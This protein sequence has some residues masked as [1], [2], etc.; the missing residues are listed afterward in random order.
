MFGLELTLSHCHLE[1]LP[2]LGIL[3]VSRGR[4]RTLQPSS[5]NIRSDVFLMKSLDRRSR[6]RHGDSQTLKLDQL[7]CPSFMVNNIRS[8]SSKSC[9]RIDNALTFLIA[10]SDHGERKFADAN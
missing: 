4:R 6:Y 1:S 10:N 9:R 5:N 3:V 8:I 7:C 2:S